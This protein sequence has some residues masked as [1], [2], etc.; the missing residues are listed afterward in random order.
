[1]IFLLLCFKML[2]CMGQKEF[3][4]LEVKSIQHKTVFL[5]FRVASTV[6]NVLVIYLK[7]PLIFILAFNI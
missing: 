6:F 3:L 2:S 1:M 4:C 7:A 5:T